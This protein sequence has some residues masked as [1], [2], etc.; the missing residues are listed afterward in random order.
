M[1]LTYIEEEK[2]KMKIRFKSKAQAQLMGALIGLMVA[3]IVGVAVVVPVVQEQIIAASGTSEIV[4]RS[5][6]ATNNTVQSLSDG[7]II[8]GSLTAVNASNG[9]AISALNFS[10]TLG[11]QSTV[12]TVTWLF[13]GT[14]SSGPDAGGTGTANLTYIVYDATYMTNRT[15]PTLLELI[16]LFLV[17]ALLMAAIVLVKF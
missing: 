9:E 3:V 8:T 2:M 13:L 10:Y 17:L 15:I 16:P 4:D 1:D 5:L 12:G 7:D 14:N 11:T 6:N